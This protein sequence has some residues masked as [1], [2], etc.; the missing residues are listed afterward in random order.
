MQPQFSSFMSNQR[1]DNGRGAEA[2]NRDVSE[3]NSTNE[4]KWNE[5]EIYDSIRQ[6]D[7]TRKGSLRPLLYLLKAG[8]AG[9][10]FVRL[11][12]PAQVLVG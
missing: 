8:A 5:D 10:V 12:E 3:T 1:Y 2:Y 7:P 4:I 6:D 11:D 9:K